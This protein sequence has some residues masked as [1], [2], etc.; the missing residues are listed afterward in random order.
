MHSFPFKKAVFIKTALLPQDFPKAIN[1]SGTPIPEIGVV[2]RSNVGKSSLLNHLFKSKNLVKTSSSP[3]KT[4]ALNFFSVD[5]NLLF[6][7]L[8][9]YGYAKVS[10]KIRDQWGPMIQ[11]YLEQ[12]KSIHLLLFLLDI[13]RTPNAYDQLFFDWASYYNVPVIIVFTKVDKVKAN[14][15]LTNT[16]KILNSFNSPNPLSYVHYST[17]KNIGRDQLIALIHQTF[18][19]K[20]I[21]QN[22]SKTQ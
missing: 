12:R 4:Q 6:V 17:T 7:D 5:D 22:L 8:P 14:E 13:R 3:G 1:A 20:T 11:N 16:Q 9:G 10:K 15:K 2:G 18:N 21:N 19:K